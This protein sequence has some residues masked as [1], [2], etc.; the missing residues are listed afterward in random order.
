MKLIDPHLHLFCLAKGQYDWLKPENPP[1]WPDKNLINRDFSEADLKLEA[2]LELGGYVHLEAGFDNAQPE[3]E[4]DWLASESTLPYRA[5]AFTDITSPEFADRLRL[6]STRAGFA[7]IRHILDEDAVTILNQPQV[8]KNLAI[9]AT[10]GY[11]FEAQFNLDNT[12]AVH[13]FIAK[14]DSCPQ[15]SVAIN[16]AGFATLVGSAEYTLWLQNMQLLSRFSQVYVKLSGWEMQDRHWKPEHCQ[17]VLDD[18]LSVFGADRLMFASNF[19]LCTFSLP[20]S[21]YWLQLIR[22]LEKRPM[23]LMHQLI[24]ANA[25]KFYKFETPAQH[26]KVEGSS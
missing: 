26:R 20:Y 2:P 25:A 12:D 17:H 16:H 19:P 3:R 22:S 18:L 14:M 7:G 24:Y 21:A 8:A 6:L 9:L 4:L 13:S 23:T 15:L 11:I 10:S 5:I 1:F